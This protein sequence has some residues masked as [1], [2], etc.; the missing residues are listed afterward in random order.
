MRNILYLLA[1][2]YGANGLFMI[3][4]PDFWYQMIP[5][6]RETGPFNEHFAIDIGI[7]FLA[8]AASLALA[9]RAN[10]DPARL[11]P[12]AVFLGGHAIFHLLE[13][14]AHGPAASVVMRDFALVVVPQLAPLA[15][16]FIQQSQSREI[17]Q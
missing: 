13:M 10:C 8:A 17:I 2:I 6:V 9:A 3:T 4:A 16:L 5:G 14:V 1:I 7:A 12:G 15:I 11:W